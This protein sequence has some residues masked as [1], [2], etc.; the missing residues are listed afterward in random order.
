LGFDENMIV[1]C[2]FASPVNIPEVIESMFR[3]HQRQRTN[4]VRLIRVGLRMTRHSNCVRRGLSDLSLK[5]FCHP[6]NRI[7]R[8]W[9]GLRAVNGCFCR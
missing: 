3:V 6:Q 1:N 7:N 5:H 4:S 2:V 9:G 8:L